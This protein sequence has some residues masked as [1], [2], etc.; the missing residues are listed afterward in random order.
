M[1]GYPCPLLQKGT[2]ATSLPTSTLA[3]H[4]ADVFLA[5]I[6]NKGKCT[7]VIPTCLN[8]AETDALARAPSSSYLYRHECRNTPA[9][10]STLHRGWKK[11]N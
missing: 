8:E 3:L 11:D 4:Y 10:R 2:L 7:L 9:D 5:Y 1:L 6:F